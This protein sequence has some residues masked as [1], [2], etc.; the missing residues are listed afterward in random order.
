[1]RETRFGFL[2]LERRSVL[3]VSAAVLA[4]GCIQPA[5]CQTNQSEVASASAASGKIDSATAPVKLPHNVIRIPLTRQ[6]TCFTCGV[7]ALQ[8]VFGYFGDE[9][10]ERVLCR[11]LG[12]NEREGTNHRKMLS[13]ASRFGYEAFAEK[14][15]PVSRLE[16]LIDHG[17]PVI[18]AMQAWPG[19][20]ADLGRSWDYGHYVVVIGYDD[21]NFYFMDPS[22]LGNYT[23]LP[24]EEFV[25]RWHDVDSSGKLVHLGIVVRKAKP[26]YD[27]DEVKRLE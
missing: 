6:S 2:L 23:F 18:V 19:K 26:V 7:A 13:V 21:R 27:A 5:G 14:D 24:R 15:M 1:M 11:K 12:A 16:D 3:L 20:P 17:Q 25:S 4:V 10:R 9:Y 22:T 8:S